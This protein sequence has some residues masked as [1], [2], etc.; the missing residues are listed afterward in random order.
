M[1]ATSA[2]CEWHSRDRPAAHPASAARAPRDIPLCA[3]RGLRIRR[4]RGGVL[5]RARRPGGRGLLYSVRDGSS[6]RC[7]SL[8]PCGCGASWHETKNE[9]GRLVSYL[10]RRCVENPSD[11]VGHPVPPT[12]FFLKLAPSRCG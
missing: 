12:R 3:L 5:P 2:S 1:P 7:P 10:L 11:D 6:V 4:G 8:V 9:R